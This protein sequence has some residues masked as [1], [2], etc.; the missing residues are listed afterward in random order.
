MFVFLCIIR[1]QPF[2]NK[3]RRPF[4]NWRSRRELEIRTSAGGLP[5]STTYILG[6][7]RMVVIGWSS[8]CVFIELSSICAWRVSIISEEV[9]AIIYNDGR[10]YRVR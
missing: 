9:I 1:Y 5:A 2:P 8:S 4:L 6:A 10:E 7:A 3:F